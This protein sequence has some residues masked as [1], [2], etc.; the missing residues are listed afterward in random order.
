MSPSGP[1]TGDG[2]IATAPA[3]SGDE[4][5]TGVPDIVAVPRSKSRIT[6]SWPSLY[7]IFWTPSTVPTAGK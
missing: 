1:Y 5:T 4:T 3:C 2:E 7:R 6:M